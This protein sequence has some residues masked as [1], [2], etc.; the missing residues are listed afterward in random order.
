M[1]VAVRP[2]RP[3]Q[4]LTGVAYRRDL[5]CGA[6]GDLL[7]RPADAGSSWRRI[8]V[9][10]TIVPVAT[11]ESGYGPGAVVEQDLRPSR[12]AELVVRV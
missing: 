1:A 8:I 4:Y 7:G 11:T 10:V 12:A 3:R 5:T 9:V 2:F 6:V